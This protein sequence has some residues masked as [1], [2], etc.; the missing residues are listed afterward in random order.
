MNEK[1]TSL[2]FMQ[3]FLLPRLHL[4]SQKYL[5]GT[6]TQFLVALNCL[7]KRDQFCREIQWRS[8]ISFRTW[9]PT[10]PANSRFKPTVSPVTCTVKNHRYKPFIL[11]RKKKKTINVNYEL[12]FDRLFSFFRSVWR[13]RPCTTRSRANPR[14]ILTV[15]CRSTCSG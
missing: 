14:N 6:Q 4:F 2:A 10:V 12:Y 9:K 7:L 11:A 15:F 1:I 13:R 3:F 5:W 8:Q